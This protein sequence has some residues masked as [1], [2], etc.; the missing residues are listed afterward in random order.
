MKRLK[1]LRVFYLAPLLL[2]ALV[3]VDIPCV[4]C[5]GTVLTE[6]FA[7]RVASDW[8]SNFFCSHSCAHDWLDEHPLYDEDGNIIRRTKE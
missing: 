2:L 7:A 4:Q 8:E 6:S 1:F 3:P 5:G